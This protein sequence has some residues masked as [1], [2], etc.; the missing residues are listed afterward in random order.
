MPDAWSPA[1]RI[2]TAAGGLAGAAGVALSAAAAHTGGAFTG[3]AAAMLLAHAPALLAVGLLGG[4]HGGRLLRLGAYCLLLGLLLFAGDLLMRD[5]V[6]HRLFAMAAPTG[7]TLMIV[8]WL[9]VAASALL[10]AVR[11]E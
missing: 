1:E 9:I 4:A 5:Y 8:G 6:G 11:G 3:T 2:L 7:G 10:P